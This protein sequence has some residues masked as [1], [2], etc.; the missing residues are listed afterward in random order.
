MK[1]N[2]MR[3]FSGYPS[4]QAVVP[5]L[6][7]HVPSMHAKPQAG[8]EIAERRNKAFAL[9]KGGLQYIEIAKQLGVTPAT[10]CRDLDRVMAD[11]AKGTVKEFPYVRQ[12]ELARCDDMLLRIHGKLIV[13]DLKATEVA[14]K[15][16]ARRLMLMG[17]DTSSEDGIKIALTQQNVYVTKQQS[18]GGAGGDWEGNEIGDNFAKIQSIFTEAGALLGGH[19]DDADGDDPTADEV[20]DSPADDH[21]NRVLAFTPS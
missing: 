7:H 13:G 1:D 14:L 18:Q 5:A 10:I 12:L 21:P 19:Q 16:Q 2:G 9:R 4:R 3:D 8:I 17:V 6:S 20:Y 11:L 15:I